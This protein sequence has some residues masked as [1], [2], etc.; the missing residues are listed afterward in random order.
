MRETQNHPKREFYFSVRLIRTARLETKR[1]AF[2]NTYIV[3]TVPAQ[4]STPNST[5]SGDKKAAVIQPVKE[6]SDPANERQDNFEVYYFAP[7]HRED[8]PSLDEL[9]DIDD[10]FACVAL[11]PFHNSMVREGL[12]DF[13]WKRRVKLVEFMVELC[14]RKGIASLVN[15]VLP[16]SKTSLIRKNRALRGQS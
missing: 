16:P 4:R 12:T 8:Y 15:S 9:P 14:K 13:G 3:K 10:R 1:C 2:T 11:K 6:R 5:V 7:W